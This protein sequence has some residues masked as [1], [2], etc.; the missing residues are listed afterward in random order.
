MND[1]RVTKCSTSH[2]FLPEPSPDPKKINDLHIRDLDWEDRFG[3]S[4]RTST[5]R[6]RLQKRRLRTDKRKRSLV[7]VPEYGHCQYKKTI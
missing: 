1:G 7:Y 3:L 2:E 5:D 6:S 4:L